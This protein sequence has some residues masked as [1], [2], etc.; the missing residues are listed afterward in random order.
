MWVFDLAYLNDI[1][2]RNDS[3]SG[4]ASYVPISNDIQFINETQ[5]DV[6]HL[7]LQLRWSDQLETTPM[8]I[9]TAKTLSASITSDATSLNTL[10]S[11]FE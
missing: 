4:N 11:S 10:R 7:N 1:E 6:D 8:V 2:R 9:P 5:F 3:I